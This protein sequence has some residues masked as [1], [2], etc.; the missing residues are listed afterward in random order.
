MKKKV[1]E[2]KIYAIC[3]ANYEKVPMLRLQGKWLRDLGFEAGVAINV[4]CENGKLIIS[5]APHD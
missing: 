3:N 2:L 1:K 4:E 5:V